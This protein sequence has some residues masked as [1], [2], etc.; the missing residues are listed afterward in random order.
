M[1]WPSS[2]SRPRA[3][4]SEAA[5]VEAGPAEETAAPRGP[6]SSPELL[7]DALLD[8]AMLEGMRERGAAKALALGRLL[9]GG[10]ALLDDGATADPTGRMP[11]FSATR[12]AGVFQTGASARTSRTPACAKAHPIIRREYRFGGVAVA[13]ERRIHGVAD[14]HGTVPVGRPGEGHRADRLPVSRRTT[15]QFH[16][17]ASAGATPE[18]VAHDRQGVGH[19]GQQRRIGEARVGEP[20][21]SPGVPGQEGGHRRAG[22]RRSSSRSLST[23]GCVMGPSACERRS[24]RGSAP[25]VTSRTHQRYSPAGSV[26]GRVKVVSAV[27]SLR[28]TWR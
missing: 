6:R 18:P 3:S 14:E 16:Q 13:L 28:M 15:S 22:Q 9:Q 23:R 19:V 21:E 17:G 1:R 11:T 5:A 12:S 2:P 25:S 4:C 27:V 8:P 10:R 24:L 7:R 20:L 26:V